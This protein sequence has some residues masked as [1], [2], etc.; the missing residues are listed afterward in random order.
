MPIPALRGPDSRRAGSASSSGAATVRSLF[1]RLGEDEPFRISL[2]EAENDAVRRRLLESA[3]YGGFSLADVAAHANRVLRSEQPASPGEPAWSPAPGQTWADAPPG[4]L[5]ARRRAIVFGALAASACARSGGER[6]CPALPVKL[7]FVV[8]GAIKGGTTALDYFLGQ[9]PEI[10]TAVQKETHFFVRDVFFRGGPPKYE[11]LDFGFQ[12]YRGERVV[13]E[14][15]PEYM[16]FSRAAER[17][18]AYNPSL[19]LILLL[20]DP[21]DRAY[22]QYRMMVARGVEDRPFGVALR[23]DLEADGGA[24]GIYTAGGFYL[25]YIRGL[26][27]RFPKRQLLLLRSEDLRRR[28]RETVRTAYSFLGVDPDFAPEPRMLL[29]GSGPPLAMA[30]RRTLV[31]LYEGEIRALE[32]FLG[33]ELGD[34]RSY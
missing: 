26:L 30:D 15:T 20:R 33:W 17:L 19:K 10:C 18:Q 4:V 32:S 16:Y 27:E 23:E 6:L 5:Q 25:R 14:S 9:H 24:E 7:S 2:L 31:L 8:A 29:T 34:W 21:A 28:H 3:G 13:G 22:S 1:A 11:W 12:D